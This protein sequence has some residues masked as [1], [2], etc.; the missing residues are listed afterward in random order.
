MPSFAHRVERWVRQWFRVGVD[1]GSSSCEVCGSTQ[2]FLF[3]SA[4]WAD[5]IDEWELSPSWAIWMDEREGARCPQCNCS[6]RIGQLG[7]ALVEVINAAT[8]SRLKCVDELFKDEQSK[9]LSIA[10]LNSAQELHNWLSRSPGLRYSEYGSITPE[11]P[12]EDLMNLS[13]PDCSFDIVIST[14]TLE[15]VPD[16]DVALRETFRILKPGGSHILTVPIVWNRA[17]RKRAE[18]VGGKVR[19]ILPPS[20]H[21]APHVGKEDFL[22]FYEFGADFVEICKAAAFDVTLIRSAKNPA[23]ATITARRPN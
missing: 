8:G 20:Y 9:G 18:I 1:R 15:H 6:Q 22:V 12:S 4:L 17:T 3:R 16:I 23:L 11:I 7:G 2:G 21:G 13:Y 5:L 10:E 19:H 14:D